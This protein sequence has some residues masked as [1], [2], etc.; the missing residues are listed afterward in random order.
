[1]TVPQLHYHLRN[2]TMCNMSTWLI[3]P[4]SALVHQCST[5]SAARALLTVAATVICAHVAIL[6]R[7]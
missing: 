7:R 5:Q 3:V 2:T 6:S 1:M 4:Q